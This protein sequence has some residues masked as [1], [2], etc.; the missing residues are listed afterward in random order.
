MSALQ[1]TALAYLD[2]R[3]TAD[4]PFWAMVAI[5]VDSLS[6]RAHAIAADVASVHPTV[7]ATAMDALPGAGSAPGV[8]MPSYGVVVDGDLLG[9]L[10]AHEPPVVARSRDDRT[11]IDLRAVAPADDRVIVDAL[12]AAAP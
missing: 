5:P 9:A 1:E 8:T 7:V 4:V 10:R 2:K 12:R 11:M 3:T 6:R